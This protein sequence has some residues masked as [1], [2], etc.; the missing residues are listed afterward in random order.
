MWQWPDVSGGRAD[1]SYSIKRRRTNVGR[2]APPEYTTVPW[3]DGALNLVIYAHYFH[4]T[5]YS[6]IYVAYR[7]YTIYTCV[8]ICMYIYMKGEICPANI[9]AAVGCPPIRLSMHGDHRLERG[10]AD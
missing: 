5:L 7:A 4:S 3:H 10:V 9:L 1:L 2:G 8:F 6:D